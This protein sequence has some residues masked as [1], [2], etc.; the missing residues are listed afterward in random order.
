MIKSFFLAPAGS[1]VGLTSATLGLVRALDQVGL[2]VGFCKPIAQH[3]D[4]PEVLDPSLLFLNETQQLDIP[5]PILLSEAQQRMAHN[6]ME[7][8]ME[9]V[10]QL[11]QQTAK[12]VDVLVVEGLVPQDNA[13]F[14][15]RINSTLARTLDSHV[16]LVAAQ[17]HQSFA[18]LNRHIDMTA[19]YY[20]GTG[21]SKVLG[22][23]LN[24]VG[25]PEEFA[26]PLQAVDDIPVTD[27]IKPIAKNLLIFDKPNFRCLG[28]IP[29]YPSAMA[30]RVSDIASHLQAKSLNPKARMERR[31]KSVSILARTIGNSLNSLK[32][33]TLVIIPGDRHDLL[34]AACMAVVNG[35]PLAGLL[36]TGDLK[37]SD[38]ILA[39]CHSAFEA[40]LPVILTHY[41]TITTT[42]KLDQMSINVPRDDIPRINRVMDFMAER[43]DSSWLAERVRANSHVRLS[44]AAFR[45]S[46]VEKARAE[47]CRIV[48]PEGDEPRTIRAAAICHRKRIA[49]CVLLGDPEQIRH[50]ADMHS[51]E[52]PDDIELKNPKEIAEHYV[53]ALVE[54]R[55]HKGLTPTMA[56]SILEDPIMVGTMMA[57]I[58]EADG[59]VAGAVNTTAATIRPALQLIKTSPDAKIVSSIFFMCL[60]DQVVVYGDC[61]VNPD[62]SAEELADIA[63]QSGDSAAAFGIEPKIAMISYSTGGSG[64]GSDV[65]KVREATKIAKAK[66]P[67]LL[68]DGPLQYDAAS[69]ASVAKS[70]APDSLVAGQA[71]VFIFPDLNTGNTTYKAVQRSAH[72]GSIGPMLQGL[73]KPVNDLSRGAL[74]DDIVYTIALTAVQAGQRKKN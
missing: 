17:N 59:L 1:N 45:Y 27:E 36:L 58:G 28:E 35:V 5:D 48:L 43:I 53:D 50:V 67:D 68:I 54:L 29:W 4:N 56:H 60:P 38:E 16:I 47:G 2:K 15:A 25:A 70:K 72:V 9:D 34:L 42:R 11:C 7:E 21:E 65:E 66:R 52:L 19:N 12:D 32:A 8:L 61:A 55:K 46:L 37:P 62:P 13:P 30:P 33:N 10:V 14:I 49:K 44:P 63:I 24:K 73:N 51:I 71:T 22:C 20:G 74:V 69:V 18:D 6:E 31:V 23:M 41:N 26:S 64:S 39:L 3:A 40:R 57:Q